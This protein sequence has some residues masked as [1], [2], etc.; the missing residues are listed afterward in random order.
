MDGALSAAERVQLEAHLATC[1]TCRAQAEE[2][3]ALRARLLSLPHPEFPRALESSVRA[4]L[5]HPPRQRRAWR[6]LL[7]LAA[8]VVLAL[9]WVRAAPGLVATQLAWDHGHCFGK[10]KLP[11]KVWSSDPAVIERWF[12]DQGTRVPRAPE[13]AFGLTLVGARYCM[14]MDRRV[15][16]L[17]YADREHRL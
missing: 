16:H 3:R 12:A 6:V 8:A 4:R 17:Y 5:V 10:E 13:S 11:A 15:A 14:L 9:L 2:E 1:P 7:P